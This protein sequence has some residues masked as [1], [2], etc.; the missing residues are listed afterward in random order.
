M[1]VQIKLL[2]QKLNSK[3]GGK[4]PAKVPARKNRSN[5]YDPA[6]PSAY[7]PKKVWDAMSKEEKEKARQDRKS[8]GIPVRSVTSLSTERVNKSLQKDL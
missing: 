8:K 1:Q 4:S 2:Q 3:K 6:N 5:K 7:V